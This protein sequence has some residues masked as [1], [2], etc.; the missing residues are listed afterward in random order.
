MAGANFL[1]SRELRS[2]VSTGG[3][4]GCSCTPATGH[5]IRFRRQC[6]SLPSRESTAIPVISAI[7]LCQPGNWSV[8]GAR[9]NV[10]NCVQ[11][12][13]T[14]KL[15]LPVQYERSACAVIAVSFSRM[16]TTHVQ[17]RSLGC[18]AL[19]AEITFTLRHDTRTRTRCSSLVLC[20]AFAL[21]FVNLSTV[22][23]LD[24][25]VPVRRLSHPLQWL[26]MGA[27][28]AFSASESLRSGVVVP[29]RPSLQL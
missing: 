2:C 4:L 28:T 26:Q 14:I 21:A 1:A 22:H 10:R 29:D 7:G 12:S 20:Y 13:S 16:S 18:H 8:A 15:S 6:S 11:L 9:I 19:T 17:R 24:V 27:A 5:V 3:T 25:Y 23:V